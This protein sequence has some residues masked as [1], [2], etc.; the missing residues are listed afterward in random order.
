M[1]RGWAGIA[2][3]AI[4]LLGSTPV[5]SRSP[6]TSLE[7]LIAAPDRYANR[8]VTVTGRFRGAPSATRAQRCLLPRTEAGGISC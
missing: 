3:S 4:V 8:A 6:A 5:L 1:L 7:A 2:I